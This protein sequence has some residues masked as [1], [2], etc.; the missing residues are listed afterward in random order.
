MNEDI[1]LMDTAK[2]FHINYS[3]IINRH[4]VREF[5]RNEF[6]MEN[7]AGIGVSKKYKQ[8]ILQKLLEIK[9]Q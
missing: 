2:F 5:R 4:Y 8:E 3:N 9:G 7:G 6:E 1:E